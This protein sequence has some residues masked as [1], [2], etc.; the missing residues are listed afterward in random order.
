MTLESRIKAF[1]ALGEQ[2]ST[3]SDDELNELSLAV[4]HEN[5][6]FTLQNIRLSLKGVAML[7]AGDALTAWASQYSLNPKKVKTVGVAMAGNIPLVGFHDFLCVL[8]SGNRLKAKLSTLDSALLKALAKKLI[9]IES[10]FSDLILFEDR[11]NDVDAMI[12]TGGNNTARY[13][14]YY[15]RSIPH[16]IRKNR[17]SCA[18]LNGMETAA[19]HDLLSTD[20]F[21]YFGL[22][23][24][25]I[26]KL[27][28]PEG[29]DF[30]LMLSTWEKFSDIIHHHKYVN[31]YDYQRSILLIN[32]IPFYDNGMVLLK[33]DNSFVSPISVLFYE[34]Y[35]DH[36]DLKSKI[37]VQKE[38][39][40]CIV[41]SAG[42]FAQSI[43]FGEAQFPKVTDY[44]DGVDTLK[45][46]EAM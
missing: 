22:G 46:L 26:S 34:Y 11:L 16:I 13:F 3:L 6:W 4:L 7:L 28:I 35:P 29:Y 25:N 40:Q 1:K 31:N 44:A 36:K 19:D 8:L 14:E 10:R 9:T 37:D 32:K 5:P 45:F 30:N 42:W 17:S 20:V 33:E 39:I 43:P 21:S 18:V 24:R 12:A 2:I 23:C 27:Y 41:S 38:K 15:F